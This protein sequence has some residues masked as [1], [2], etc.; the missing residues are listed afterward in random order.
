[1]RTAQAGPWILALAVLG[2]G[3]VSA[4]PPEKHKF[5]FGVQGGF[6]YVDEDL[7]GA[8][9][10]TT[11][12]TLGLRIGGPF[13]LKR[14]SWFADALYT[15]IDT[16]TFR[17]DARRAEGRAGLELDL[18][19]HRQNPWYLA[20]AAGFTTIDFDAAESFDSAVASVGIGQW[21]WLSGNKYLRWELRGDRTLAKDGLVAA[22]GSSSDIVDAK[23]LI[24]LHWRLGK[25]APRDADGD[26]VID[27]RDR[28][29]DTPAGTPVDRRGC[30]REGA[31]APPSAE[32]S[33][34]APAA[35]AAPPP[36]GDG[37]GVPDDADRCPTTIT[38]VEVD[39]TGCPRDEDGD[40]VYDG[41]G[42]DRCPG[43]PEGAVVDIHGCP[44]DGDGDGVWDGLDRCPDTP[45]GA[46]VG[47]DGCPPA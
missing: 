33:P 15:E 30:P 5:D 11:E 18:T 44:L 37:D 22:D 14:F 43:T 36:D 24:G 25:R 27:R 21:V 3:A 34:E 10:P 20:G 40:G 6:V 8:D 35:P 16:R 41:L 19:P 2:A 39:A 42:M 26:G 9:G 47:D 12:P 38:G 32:I 31:A 23:F 4:A 46:E 28:C 7:A 13:F 17:G 29:G 45:A 1:M